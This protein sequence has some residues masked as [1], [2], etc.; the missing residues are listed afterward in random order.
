MASELPKACVIGAGSSGLPVIKALEERAIPVT[1]Y[2]KTA[3]IGGLWCI[4]NKAAGATAA[5]DSLHINTDT[6]IDGGTRDSWFPRR[7][8]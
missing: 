8:S 4:E 3:N 2:E 6:R 5:Y 1:R 7:G